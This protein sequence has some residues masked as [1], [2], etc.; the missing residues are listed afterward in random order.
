MP[1]SFCIK[2]YVTRPQFEYVKHKSLEAG[3]ATRA[4]YVRSMLIG[5][6]LYIEQKVLESN[7]I[8][9]RLEVLLNSWTEGTQ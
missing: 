7:E 2:V 3:F 1:K 9:K 6:R 4:A 5:N 8:L